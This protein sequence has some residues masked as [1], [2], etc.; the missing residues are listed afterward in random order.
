MDFSSKVVF[1][2]SFQK[3]E[4]EEGF[5]WRKAEKLGQC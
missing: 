1:P 4:T 5:S 2:L 3:T